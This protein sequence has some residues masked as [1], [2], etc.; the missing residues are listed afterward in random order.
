M[1]KR[2]YQLLKILKI[3]IQKQRLILKFEEVDELVA[4]DL[5]LTKIDCFC[6]KTTFEI[7]VL[8]KAHD[9][10]SLNICQTLL[11]EIW[12]GALEPPLS[13]VKVI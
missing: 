1:E 4:K 5:L 9:F 7:A 3:C 2:F 10:V 13:I 8:A 11:T 12:Y 6:Q